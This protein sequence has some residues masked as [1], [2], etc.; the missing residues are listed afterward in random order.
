MSDEPRTI[1][2]GQIFVFT[3]GE[4]EDYGIVEVFVAEKDFP[5]KEMAALY[6]KI[7][8]SDYTKLTERF[9]SAVKNRGMAHPIE[10]EEVHTDY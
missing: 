7:D 6:E 3:S 4:Y 10:W 9:L 1:K 2:A 5:A 8:R